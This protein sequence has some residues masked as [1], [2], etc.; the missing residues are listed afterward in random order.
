MV[1]ISF[2]R[3]HL[4]QQG[5]NAFLL[6]LGD[7]DQRIPLLVHQF[8]N[9]LAQPV[10][11]LQRFPGAGD[12]ADI[13]GQIQ[14]QIQQLL[15][16]NSR[17]T[18]TVDAQ[19]ID[20]IHNIPLSGI[21]GKASGIGAAAVAQADLHG[22]PVLLGHHSLRG[23][24]DISSFRVFRCIDLTAVHMNK[25]FILCRG[26]RVGQFLRKRDFIFIRS[27]ILRQ[28]QCFLR[29]IQ[30]RGIMVY[31][32]LS[33]GNGSCGF[34]LNLGSRNRKHRSVRCRKH[35]QHRQQQSHRS[36]QHRNKISH[37]YY[38]PILIRPNFRDI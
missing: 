12:T 18:G 24:P 2:L 38:P 15:Q 28:D 3:E 13:G 17:V 36:F 26:S 31:Q 22:L 14:R 21:P 9:R 19:L 7:G 27:H 25:G 23:N 20:H 30:L 35:H 5:E 8:G 16:I 34:C 4:I 1:S 11:P 6:D 32:Y 29:L 10:D 33:A 37:F